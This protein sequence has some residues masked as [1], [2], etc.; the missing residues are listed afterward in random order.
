MLIYYIKNTPSTIIAIEIA[1]RHNAKLS[2]TLIFFLSLLYIIK[3]YL[4]KLQSI[5][6]WLKK[7]QHITILQ[8]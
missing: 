3:K 5:T 1:T 8:R 7:L 6:Y 2:E 4:C